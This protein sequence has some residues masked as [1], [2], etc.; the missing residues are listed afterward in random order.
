MTGRYIDD[1]IA[2]KEAELDALEDESRKMAS[3]QRG[4]QLRQRKVELVA[5]LKALREKKSTGRY[6]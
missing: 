1:V 6:Q 4:A 5:E 2:E 3:L